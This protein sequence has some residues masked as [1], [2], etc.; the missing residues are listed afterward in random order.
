MRTRRFEWEGAQ[1][2]AALIRAWSTELE[3][4][5][6]VSEIFDQVVAGGDGVLGQRSADEAVV[7]AL[8]TRFDAT[9][10]PRVGLAVDP[11]SAAAALAGIQPALREALELAA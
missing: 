10:H 8:T 1:R 7:L 6:D 3:P 5:V 4:E 2:T 9:D 11:E